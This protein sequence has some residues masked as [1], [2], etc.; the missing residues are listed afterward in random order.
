M[1]VPRLWLRQSTRG[2]KDGGSLRAGW[3][4]RVKDKVPRGRLPR[5]DFASIRPNP[6]LRGQFLVL[7]PRDALSVP[8]HKVQGIGSAN[9]CIS[10]ALLGSF[11]QVDP[12][13]LGVAGARNLRL[14][15]RVARHQI[16][17]LVL[18]DVLLD[19][20]SVHLGDGRGVEHLVVPKGCGNDTPTQCH[21]EDA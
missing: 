4:D 12:A 17:E 9:R 8:T 21:A 16:E 19:L 1:N 10:P 3:E 20:E 18:D 6:K 13:A 14:Q 5:R 2:D 11:Q 15:L 7:G